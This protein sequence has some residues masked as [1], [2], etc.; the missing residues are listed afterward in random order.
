MRLAR[1]KGEGGKSWRVA[2]AASDVPG[3][4]LAPREAHPIEVLWMGSSTL[5]L[6]PRGAP[7]KGLV[8]ERG[9]SSLVDGMRGFVDA[10]WDIVPS[11]EARGLLLELCNL[12]WSKKRELA[13]DNIPLYLFDDAL[14][15]WLWR[16]VNPDSH[17]HFANLPDHTE[18]HS[19]RELPQEAHPDPDYYEI[20][21]RNSLL[22]RRHLVLPSRAVDVWTFPRPRL[23]A[24]FRHKGS[25]LGANSPI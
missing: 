20:V 19:F 2:P 15:D 5:K 14:E 11:R 12:K 8:F 22:S 7:G 10:V 16:R 6:E 23:P 9:E 1:A 24:C 13:A 4:F 18:F 3:S 21:G 17:E 25:G